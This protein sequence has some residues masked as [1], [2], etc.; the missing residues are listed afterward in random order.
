MDTRRVDG[1][2]A[3]QHRGTAMLRAGQ[4]AM[5]GIRVKPGPG[6]GG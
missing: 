3:P 1:A 2:K 5:M 4:K 6:G